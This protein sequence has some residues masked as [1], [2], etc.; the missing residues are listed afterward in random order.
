MRTLLSLSPCSRIEAMTRQHYFDFLLSFSYQFLPRLCCFALSLLRIDKTLSS[1]CREGGKGGIGGDGN[2]CARLFGWINILDIRSTY[3]NHP[4]PHANRKWSVRYWAWEFLRIQ[5]DRL[6]R[7]KGE[8]VSESS[9]DSSSDE[10]ERHLMRRVSRQ[11]SEPLKRVALIPFGLTDH[12]LQ[13][14]QCD[15][16]K[17]TKWKFKYDFGS[18]I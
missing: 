14:T 17:E 8:E 13:H 11:P 16:I 5:V 2:N 7:Q 4:I 10:Y 1:K 12:R 6:T 3:P 15:N 18:G 9:S